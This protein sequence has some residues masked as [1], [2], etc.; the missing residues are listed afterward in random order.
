[1]SAT[2]KVWFA[3]GLIVAAASAVPYIAAAVCCAVV[4]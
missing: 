1:M 2:V 3:C 4:L